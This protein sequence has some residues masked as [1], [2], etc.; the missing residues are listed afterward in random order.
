MTRPNTQVK[1]KSRGYDGLRLILLSLGD[2]H[3]WFNRL[4]MKSFHLVLARVVLTHQAL[5][6]FSGRIACFRGRVGKHPQRCK[7]K[8]SNHP[9]WTARASG[10]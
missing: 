1:S 3:P 2:L 6:S 9:S 5:E 8:I 4:N 10:S 7:Y